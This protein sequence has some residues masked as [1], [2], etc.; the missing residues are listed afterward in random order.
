[1]RESLV[2]L[3]SFLHDLMTGLWAGALLTM[4]ALTAGRGGISGQAY[5]LLSELFQQ[6]NYLAVA[7]LMIILLTGIGR[8]I[9]YK[10]Y[11]WT[12]DVAAKRKKLLI[13]KHIFLGTLITAGT[14]YQVYLNF[15]W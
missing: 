10:Y 8:A 6:L 3:N 1:M 13:I 9:T 5:L 14:G 15:Q 7:C 12:G 2:V 11:G 4:R